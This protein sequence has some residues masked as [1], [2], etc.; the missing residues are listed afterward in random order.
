[1]K[2]TT[3]CALVMFNVAG[4][5]TALETRTASATDQ[6][7][8]GSAAQESRRTGTIAGQVI[9]AGTLQPLAGAQVSVA[10]TSIGVVANAEGRFT[11]VNVPAG[12]ATV[13]VRL[14]GYA[15]GEQTATVRDGETATLDFELTP[16]AIALDEVVVTALGIEREAYTLG[17]ATQTVDSEDLSPSRSGN[18]VNTLQGQVAGLSLQTAGSGVIGTTRITLRGE[19]TLDLGRNEALIVVDGI[20]I[21]NRTSGTGANSYLGDEVPIDYGDGISDLNPDDIESV[22]VLK[23][24]NA[25]ALYGSRAS[26]GAII[27]TTKSAPAQQNG[28]GITYSGG[29]TFDQITRWP[30][31]QMEYGSGSRT[32][33][34]LDYYSFTSEDG[35]TANQSTHSWGLPFEGQPFHQYQPGDSTAV[36]PWAPRDFIKGFFETGATTHH[37]LSI[38]N[39]T[40]WGS[41]RL[42]LSNR[43]N[44]WIVPNTGTTMNAIDLNARV[45]ITDDLS[46]NAIGR[47]INRSSDNLPSVGYGSS[48]PMYFFTWM[49]NSVDVNWLRNYWLQEDQLQDNRINPNSDNPFF[50]SYEQLDT[51]DRDRLIGTLSVDVTPT[52]DMHL[53]VRTARDQ[54]EEFRTTIRPMSSVRAPQGMYREQ[55]VTYEDTNT[56]FLFSYQP[57]FT[58]SGFLDELETQLSVGGNYR[59]TNARDHMITAEDLAL[60]GVYN[61]GNSAIRPLVDKSAAESK[62]YSLYSMLSL[63]RR[64]WHLDLTARNDWSSTLPEDNNSYFYPSA[65]LS[66]VPSELFDMGYAIDFAKLRFAISRVGNATDPYRLDKYYSFHDFNGS[67]SNPNTIPNEDLKPEIVTSYEIGV[68]LR[69]IGGRLNLDATA[70]H[71]ESVNQII[72]VPIDPSTG[73]TSA[74]LNAGQINNRGV[75]LMAGFTPVRTPDFQWQGRL[76]WATNRSEVIELAE[77][78]DNYVLTSGISNRVFVEAR[79]G[80]EFGDIY[81]RGY[82]RSPD[83]EIVHDENGYPMLTDEFIVTGNAFPDW[84]GGFSNQFTYKGV[85]LNTL[86]D[87]R[88][89]GDVYS[90]TYAALSYSGKLTNTLEGRYDSDITPTGVVQNPDGSYSPNTLQPVN[91]GYYYDAL[92]GRDNVEANTLDTSFLKLREV[93]LA[94]DLPQSWLNRIPAQRATVTLSGRNLYTGSSFGAFDP[95]AAT[96]NGNTLYPGIET[97]QFP[98]TTAYGFNVRLDF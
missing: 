68:D 92:Y 10:G 19:N 44:S 64:W 17:Y 76:N 90:L 94:F 86:F 82:L 91:I 81:G 78:V 56:D 95:E 48:S 7:L 93:S 39:A 84:T 73:F 5:A 38:S 40:E 61:L 89:G 2:R 45:N 36:L 8:G 26:N 25:A 98:S 21:N 43:D 77:G 13:Q 15:V 67:L 34:E 42:S 29:M 20:P 46:V 33:L 85:R 74:L 57:T 41:F 96:M 14:L 69:L 83:G 6:V 12:A 47:Y 51:Q 58:G 97:G 23:G 50:Q 53:M 80:E 1:M 66:L 60:P 49:N 28:I 52:A 18:W 9:E 24:P 4:V 59:Y 87:F 75:E 65:S 22:T 32:R 30:D 70:Y 16:E 62:M 79:P 88:K 54:S 71:S 3:V 37:N 63:G 11:L 55:T 35:R 27:I 72:D 31:Y